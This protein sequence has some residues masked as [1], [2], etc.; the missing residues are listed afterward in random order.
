MEW[1][2]YILV[3]TCIRLC[4]INV[5]E[6]SVNIKICIFPSPFTLMYPPSTTSVVRVSVGEDYSF[7]AE[8]VN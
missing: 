1:V 7:R 5:H 2:I 6:Q 3:C 4:L 8:P